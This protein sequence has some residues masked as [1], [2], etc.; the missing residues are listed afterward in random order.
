MFRE[1]STL[2]LP[3][4]SLSLT[5]FL[6]LVPWKSPLGARIKSAH[7]LSAHTGSVPQLS[8]SGE[9]LLHYTKTPELLF[10]TFS[11]DEK[12]S[13]AKSSID[14]LIHPIITPHPVSGCRYIYLFWMTYIL[15]IFLRFSL[16][17]HQWGAIVDRK[18][19][20]VNDVRK[21]T[22]FIMFYD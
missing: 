12:F 8:L 21:A 16:L 13:R 18:N 10:F 20:S 11:P 4:I 9:Y 2:T 3:F 14:G 15:M 6:P 17:R 19:P 1:L 5:R 7:V 22:F